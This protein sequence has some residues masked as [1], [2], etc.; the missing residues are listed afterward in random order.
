LEA[1]RLAAGQVR[2]AVRGGHYW[3]GGQRLEQV[4][5]AGANRLVIEFTYH[6]ARR[7][8]EP[9]SF[10]RKGTGNLLLYAWEQGGRTIKSF[11]TAE[12]S[13]VS[14]TDLPFTPRYL[15]ELTGWESVGERSSDRSTPGNLAIVE[16]WAMRCSLFSQLRRRFV[17]R[18]PPAE[19]SAILEQKQTRLGIEQEAHLAEVDLRLLAGRRIVDAN[20][21]G[22][23]V[24]AQ[25]LLHEAP[26]RVVARKQAVIANEQRVDLREPQRARLRVPC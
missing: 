17:P 18:R 15:V 5:F 20:R 23:L 26:E 22:P 9:Y 21:G 16:G 13:D 4:R 3:G 2:V 19:R 24:P 11:N 25:L 8:A 6:G 1:V 10:R 14:V 7:R 12:M